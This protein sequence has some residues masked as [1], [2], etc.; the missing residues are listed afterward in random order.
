MANSADDKLI[1]FIVFLENR[2]LQSI[3]IGYNLH[4]MLKSVFWEEYFNMSSA[5]NFT[6]MLSV[7]MFAILSMAR[8]YQS[9]N[10]P[11]MEFCCGPPEEVTEEAIPEAANEPRCDPCLEKGVKLPAEDYCHDCSQFYCTTCSDVHSRL[12]ITRKHITKKAKD[13]STGQGADYTRDAPPPLRERSSAGKVEHPPR[14]PPRPPVA[15]PITSA[16]SDVK[17]TRSCRFNVKI[18]EDE[19][20][21]DIFGIDIAPD[22]R[23][24]IADL[25]NNRIKVFAKDRRY[26]S[27]LYVPMPVGIFVVSNREA[28]VTFWS[29]NNFSILDISGYKLS[30]KEVVTLDCTVRSVSAYQDK[31][32]VTCLDQPRSVKMVD[33]RGKVYWSRSLGTA[34]KNLFARPLYNT[35]AMEGGR[36]VV[37]VSDII[38]GT[39]TKLDGSTGNIICVSTIHDLTAAPAFLSVDPSGRLFVSFIGDWNIGVWTKDLKQHKNFCPFQADTNKCLSCVKFD[40][41]TRILY[42][43][44]D[45]TLSGSRNFIEGSLVHYV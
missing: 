18:P 9:E 11:P 23:M 13:R 5:E 12:A 34:G 29:K 3:S 20:G 19:E 30:V 44:Y 39:I 41:S 32:F 17:L 8:R 26:L 25:A 28:L 24:F 21:C 7:N 40:E 38:K 35:C 33:R 27:S 16:L 4:E 45:S 10:T 1:F 37:F 22:G 15:K 6:Q 2:I 31:Y 36:L 14:V 43:A 42:V